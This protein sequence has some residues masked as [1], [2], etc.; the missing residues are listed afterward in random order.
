MGE[1][2]LW[3]IFFSLLFFFRLLHKRLSF[4]NEGESETRSYSHGDA[5]HQTNLQKKAFKKICGNETTLQETRSQNET[6]KN[7]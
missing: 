3:A 1:K 2:I 5:I 7:I 4:C 6:K